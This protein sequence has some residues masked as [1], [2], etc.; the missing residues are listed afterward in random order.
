MPLFNWPEKSSCGDTPPDQCAPLDVRE[1]IKSIRGSDQDT[2]CEVD[3]VADQH[4]S[5]PVILSDMETV[6]R[7]GS[8]ANPIPINLLQEYGG[9][10]PV[11]SI[12][13]KNLAGELHAWKPPIGCDGKKVVVEGGNFHIIDDVNSNVFE[14]SCIGSS[15]DADYI[16]G[17]KQF[18]DCNGVVKIKL[19]FFPKAQLP[20]YIS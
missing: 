2:S 6:A 7:S 4:P 9:A 8:T 1:T 20:P 19:V 15:S 13:Y 12:L 16:A 14:E 10:G 5:L 11:P 17:A 18:I 3:L